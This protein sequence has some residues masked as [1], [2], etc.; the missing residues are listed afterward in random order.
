LARDSSVYEI[1]VKPDHGR[2][3]YELRLPWSELGIWP[4]AG[5]KFGFSV[6]LNDNDGG[7]PAARMNWGGGLS[8]AWHPSGF[9][10]IT[11]AE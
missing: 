10:I 11:L 5:A 3:V 6:Q 2:C 7:G 1:T 4:A 8:P 9:G